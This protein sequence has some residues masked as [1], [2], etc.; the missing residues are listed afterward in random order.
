MAPEKKVRK[1]TVLNRASWPHYQSYTVRTFA[2]GI[3]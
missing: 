1:L 2:H 3:T